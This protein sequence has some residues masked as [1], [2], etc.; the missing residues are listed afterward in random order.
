MEQEQLKSEKFSTMKRIVM[1]T[2]VSLI[3]IVATV[4]VICFTLNQKNKKAE[5]VPV[6]S[7]E[8][9]TENDEIKSLV[10]IPADF[11]LQNYKQED[12][13]TVSSDLGFSL[14]YPYKNVQAMLGMTDDKEDPKFQTSFIF[15][16]SLVS[17]DKDMAKNSIRI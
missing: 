13:N 10:S 14:K 9:K 4:I 8:L 16:T 2:I 12:L 15:S 5:I 6:E 7:T 17:A 1:S 3:I 11:L